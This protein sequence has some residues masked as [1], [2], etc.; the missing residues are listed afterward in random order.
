MSAQYKK[1]F[2][3][4]FLTKT[5]LLKK[6]ANYLNPSCTFVKRWSHHYGETVC[7]CVTYKS[8]KCSPFCEETT[9]QPK[10]S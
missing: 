7:D 1:L 4:A 10:R 2:E 5:G 3:A 8:E 9:A 6:P